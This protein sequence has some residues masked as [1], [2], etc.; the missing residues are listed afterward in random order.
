MRKQQLQT[1]EVG[2]AK[3]GFVGLGHMGGAMVGRLLK[4]GHAVYGTSRSR[5]GAG[6][7]IEDGLQWRGTPREVAQASDVVFTSLPDDR[8]VED[9]VVGNGGEDDI[10]GLGDLARSVAP[11][12]PRV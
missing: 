2:A 6:A 9:V 5:E 8:T 10:D 4:S 12:K 1:R 7:L 11:A 3:I